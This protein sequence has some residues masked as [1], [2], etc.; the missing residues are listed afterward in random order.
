MVA[1][2]KWHSRFRG[3]SG[4]APFR[5]TRVGLS[6][7]Y[8][9]A[10]LTLTVDYDNR[11][12]TEDVTTTP[13]PGDP[14]GARLVTASGQAPELFFLPGVHPPVIKAGHRAKVEIIYWL[15]AAQLREALFLESRGHRLTVKTATPFALDQVGNQQSIVFT[16]PEWNQP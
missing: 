14:N 11:A 3:E 2:H 15:D 10:I 1:Y 9:N 7:D 5:V 12:G 13:A 8:G 6:R 16:Q 4:D